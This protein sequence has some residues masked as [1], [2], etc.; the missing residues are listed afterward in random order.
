MRTTDSAGMPRTAL[1]AVEAPTP[2]TGSTW[3]SCPPE[4]PDTAASRSRP[5]GGRPRS[6]RLLEPVVGERLVVEGGD[7]DV[8]RPA[9]HRDRLGEVAVR[10][11][12]DRPRAV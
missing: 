4:Y 8:S 1:R 2:C 6:E 12:P 3:R 5:R 7:L 9:V 10:L 11:Q